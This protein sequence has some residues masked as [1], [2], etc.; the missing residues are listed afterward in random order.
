M[1]PLAAAVSSQEASDV[2]LAAEA[3]K[4]VR[5]IG[6][7]S[8]RLADIF[9]EFK[10]RG[11]SQRQIATECGTNQSTVCWYLKCAERFPRESSRPTL[12]SD[13]RKELF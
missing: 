1:K 6:L 11:R 13:C 9:A 12:N 5:Q 3:K 8:W 4:L 2:A 7:G 10:Q